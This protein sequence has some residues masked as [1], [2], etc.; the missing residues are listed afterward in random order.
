VRTT[1]DLP[2]DLIDEAKSLTGLR[3]K[4]AVVLHALEELVRRE[5]GRRFSARLGS[6]DL[7]LT[8]EQLEAMRVD[9]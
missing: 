7:D 6:I 9:D 1:V 8:Q 2:E 3:T 4:R 5:R